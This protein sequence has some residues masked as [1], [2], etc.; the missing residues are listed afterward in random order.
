MTC[1]SSGHLFPSISLSS[2]TLVKLKQSKLH[3]TVQWFEPNTGKWG[4]RWRIQR[5]QCQWVGQWGRIECSKG[6]CNQMT[7]SESPTMANPAQQRRIKPNHGES[8]PMA[9]NPTQW[10][11]VKPNHGEYPTQ[12]RIQPDGDKPSPTWWI[13]PNDSE[14]KPWWVFNP[15]TANTTQPNGDEFNPMTTKSRPHAANSTRHIDSEWDP[16]IQPNR[17]ELNL[18]AQ[19]NAAIS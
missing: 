12:P 8:N 9:T 10:Q 13:Q 16:T 2:S 17:S 4:Q 14:W 5:N 18:Q 6:E 7:V 3:P 19:P 1:F 11:W 15:T